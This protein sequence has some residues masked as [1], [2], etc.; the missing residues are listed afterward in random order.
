MQ[1]EEADVGD[2]HGGGCFCKV[3]KPF[4]DF[5]TSLAMLS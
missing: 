3:K 1:V 4:K 2:H 5:T